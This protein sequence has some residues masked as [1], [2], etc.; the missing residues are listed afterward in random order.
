M[1]KVNVLVVS[2]THSYEGFLKDLQAVDPRVV[3]RDATGLFLD[4]LRRD[5]ITDPMIPRIEEMVQRDGAL[6]VDPGTEGRSLDSLLSEAEVAFGVIM[7]PKNIISRAPGLKWFHI[8]G[9]GIDRYVNS[10]IFDG[11]ITVT[12]SRGVLAVPI[13]EYVM[14]FIFTLAKNIP[15]L[16][17]AKLERRWERFDTIELAGGT[18]GI[19]G[20]GA[21]GTQVARMAKGVGMKVIATRR[22]ANRH[23]H[24]IGHVDEVYP[25]NDLLEML[26][27]SDFLV[28][29]LPLTA[30]TRKL[31][32]EPELRAMKPTAH[33]INVS[34][35]PIIDEPVLIRALQE[36]W[37]A[38]AGLDVFEKEPLPLESE[39]WG[40]P[41]VIFSH[42][43]AG[44]TDRRGY[45]ISRLFCENLTRYV[46]GQPLFNIVSRGRGY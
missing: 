25:R 35:G 45:H 26:A 22:S 46:S 13:A 12:N 36:G 9:T 16:R 11:R 38:G 30:E 34:R 44:K 5:G 29:A 2:R 6:G 17:R 33:L 40:M 10:E 31:V 23:E 39:L 42:H 43:M 41:N 24:G 20:M 27:E 14:A 3:A 28:L 32:G 21:I 37:I 7:W 19:I 8:G 4:E 1:E 15:R 18:L